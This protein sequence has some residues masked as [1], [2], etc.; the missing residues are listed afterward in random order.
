[1]TSESM[2][3][4]YLVYKFLGFLFGFVIIYLG[5]ILFKKGFSAPAG[6]LE[7]SLVGKNIKLANAAP[8]TFLFVLGAAVIIISLFKGTELKKSTKSANTLPTVTIDT[9]SSVPDS[10]PTKTLN[11]DSLYEKGIAFKDSGKLLNAYRTY[12]ILKGALNENDSSYDRLRKDVNVIIKSLEKEIN[13][14]TSKS[15]KTSLTVEETQSVTIS[16][17][18]VDSANISSH[19]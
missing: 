9:I 15:D 8:G 14:L 5:Y 10:Q 17:E 12:C 2:I 3:I 6:S 16:D 1:M 19:E 4:V 11:I 7:Y 18:S 13:K